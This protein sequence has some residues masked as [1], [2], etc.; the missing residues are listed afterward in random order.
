MVSDRPG[1]LDLRELSTPGQGAAQELLAALGLPLPTGDAFARGCDPPR[2]LV[3]VAPYAAVELLARTLPW[4]AVCEHVIAVLD[5]RTPLAADRSLSKL[6]DPGW[7]EALARLP[8]RARFDWFAG[9]PSPC[10]AALA[11]ASALASGL[12]TRS[13][14]AAR[15]WPDL[16]L[17]ASPWVAFTDD[18]GGSL[19]AVVASQLVTHA[20]RPALRDARGGVHD[21]AALH[22]PI[23]FG[24]ATEPALPL[25]GDADGHPG[26]RW[27]ARDPVHP[28]A[29]RVERT[30]VAWSYAGARELG[31]LA[32]SSA[33]PPASHVERRWGR[34]ANEVVAISLSPDGDACVQHA[35]DDALLTTRPP[36]G[37]QR[38]GSV[39]VAS[40]APDPARRLLAVLAT[41]VDPDVLQ[42]DDMP[43]EQVRDRA[44]VIVLGPTAATR[45]ALA[46]GDH[47]I[48]FDG[49]GRRTLI[50]RV[51][52]SFW[53]LD[54]DH[55]VVRTAPGRLLGGWFRYATVE[56][57][58]ALYREHLAT[59]E[60][61]ALAV[62]D[63]VVCADPEIEA[64]AL[65]ALAEGRPADAAALR[66]SHPTREITGER[67]VVAIPGT[68][69]VLE[70]VGGYLRVV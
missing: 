63:R 32:V 61:V 28:V 39:D 34:V 38:A 9:E 66:A 14:R 7:D 42:L 21:L 6:F 44:P 68:R 56:H 59:G 54:A 29:W 13:P 70:L 50:R 15:P 45:Y 23:A 40:C 26:G 2:V 55:R 33:S 16:E 51:A 30:A 41:G 65:D 35:V 18:A 37:W 11:H 27:L 31:F 20:G 62:A 64:I 5:R 49:D 25:A 52:D 48:A 67:T 17:P 24:T 1:L 10:R 69:N 8:L 43:S 4:L 46:A 53:V 22:G 57:E 19:A 3:L 58:G 36:L 60:R 12:A 47:L